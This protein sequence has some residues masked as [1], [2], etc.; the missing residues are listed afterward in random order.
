MATE[1]GMRKQDVVAQ[2]TQSPHG[3]LNAYREIGGKVAYED[4]EFLAHVIAWDHLKG[5]VRDAKIA[6]PVLAIRDAF[7][8][9]GRAEYL[10]NA[11]AHL[12]LADPRTLLRG[13]AWARELKVPVAALR[14]LVERY[15][16][17]RE[18]VRGWWDK[19]AL[20][21]RRSLSSLYWYYG[22]EKSERAKAVLVGAD[23]ATGR[24]HIPYPPGSVFEVVAALK[25]MAP[26]AAAAA[27]V[28]HKIPYLVA[29]G[30]LG[31]KLKDTDV[32]MALIK[33]MTA[34][35]LVTN[36]KALEK[37]GVKKVP[38]LRATL[39]EALSKAAD[40]RRVST[41]TFKAGV[42]QAAMT[43]P[44]LKAKL[45][46]LQE[47][48]LRE[49]TVEGDWLVLGDKSG[50]M[51]GAIE[52]ARMV[53]GAL[54]KAVKGRVRLTFFDTTPRAFDATGQT[55]EAIQAMTKRITSGGGTII[56]CGLMQAIDDGFIPDGIAIVSDGGESAGPSFVLA[57]AALKQKLQGREVP[58]YLYRIGGSADMLSPSMRA[59][60]FDMQ[61]FEVA[62]TADYYSLP[63]LIKTMRVNRYSLIQE[64][65][66]TDMLTLDEVYKVKVKAE[67]E[68]V[69]AV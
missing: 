40:S 21:H 17:E 19:T 22:I 28:K 43:D 66:D 14:H 27:V 65:M 31:P 51:Q 4:P 35:E 60:G 2:L 63:N 54:A 53:A 11:Q 23:K 32:L 38:A 44:V 20:Q 30:A 45:G 56:G 7:R 3:D 49:V 59:H 61:L 52:T 34:T 69:G 42:A 50:S 9:P 6:L 15:I 47:K 46:A 57:Y 18:K 55:Y 25:N 68:E 48:Q 33:S 41:P 39:E 8:A 13:L 29:M 58:V 12:S 36:M 10:E 64:I 5:Q 67:A 62:T 1:T 37:L 26:I 24:K 16:K